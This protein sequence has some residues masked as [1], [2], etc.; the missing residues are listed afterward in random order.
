MSRGRAKT[1]GHRIRIGLCDDESTKCS[2]SSRLDQL[3][4]S[5][6]FTPASTTD[7]HP[8]PSKAAWSMSGADYTPPLSKSGREGVNR[9][10]AEAT[11]ARPFIRLEFAAPSVDRI[12]RVWPAGRR[13]CVG[14]AASRSI[15][16]GLSWSDECTATCL[17]FFGDR[18]NAIDVGAVAG[19]ILEDV[20]RQHAELGSQ[21]FGA[22]RC[23]R[24]YPESRAVSER[25]ESTGDSRIA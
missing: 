3:S 15:V 9:L 20:A 17:H 14:A 1:I 8:T 5:C 11:D 18:R 13:F 22:G 24:V 6:P 7:S 21:Q 10:V 19:R 4:G 2:G 12:V 25:T 23:D 16:H